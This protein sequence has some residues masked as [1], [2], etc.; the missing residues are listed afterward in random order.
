MVTI[1]VVDRNG[2]GVPSAEVHI[3]WSGSWTHSRG[4]TNCN[5]EVSF[6]VSPGTGKILVDGREK[7]GETQISGMMT[8]DA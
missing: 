5:G 4:R 7:T 8:V 2:R 3:S 1:R 6:D